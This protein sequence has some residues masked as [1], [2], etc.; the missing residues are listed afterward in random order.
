MNSACEM[1]K[2]ACCEFLALNIKS[3]VDNDKFKWLAY[4]GTAYDTVIELDV[5]CK[6]LVD[7]KCSYYDG[8][9]SVCK[10]M[11]VGSSMCHVAIARQRTDQ[12][13]EI[14]KKLH[15]PMPPDGGNAL[16]L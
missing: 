14:F 9:P 13:H 7:G 3:L 12:R 2:G 11:Q 1:C 16:N 8:R 5:K 15:E 10:N 4:H 6:H